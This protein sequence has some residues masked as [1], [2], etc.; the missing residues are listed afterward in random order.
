MKSK[1]IA[2]GLGAAMS[3]AALPGTALAED[4]ELML[5]N[6]SSRALIVFQTSPSGVEEWE[7]DVLGDGVLP[8]GNE[9][10]VIIADRRDVCIYDMRFVMEDETVLEAYEYDICETQQFTLSDE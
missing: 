6:L 1:L 9:V 7:E 3:L 2:V 5:T 10:P 8:S 4:L